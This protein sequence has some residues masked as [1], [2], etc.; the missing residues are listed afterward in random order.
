MLH[1]R[2][3][4]PPGRT[5]AA[6]KLIAST[7]GTTHLV[8]LPGA[9][10]DPAGDVVMCDVAREAGDELIS[11]LR[12]LRVDQDGSIA[13]ENIDLSSPSAP[14]TPRRRPRASPR[15]R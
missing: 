6:V 2:M 13:V 8:V 12:E 10:R 7:V 1:L 4:V 14:K 11:G 15:T 3:I 9:A 5:A